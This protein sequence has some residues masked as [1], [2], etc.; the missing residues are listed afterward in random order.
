[1]LDLGKRFVTFEIV[2]KT[3]FLQ[4]EA[5]KWTDTWVNKTKQ[6]NPQQKIYLVILQG[7]GN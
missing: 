2:G 6:E 3:K 7:S 1:M 4:F 5:R